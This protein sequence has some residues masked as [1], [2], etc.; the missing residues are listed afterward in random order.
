MPAVD[1]HGWQCCRG[2]FHSLLDSQWPLYV[3]KLM[4]DVLGGHSQ[5]TAGT[6]AECV[7]CCDAAGPVPATGTGVGAQP[8]T[9]ASASQSP[10]SSPKAPSSPP[11][12]HSGAAADPS[13]C[14]VLSTAAI[15]AALLLVSIGVI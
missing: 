15:G 8:S 6:S 10:L 12:A 3:P 11:W 7:M 9:S 2:V 14:S 4:N 13:V 1:L 5:S